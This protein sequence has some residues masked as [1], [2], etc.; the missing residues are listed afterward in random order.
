MAFRFLLRTMVLSSIFGK[1][2]ENIMVLS[3]ISAENHPK[4][5]AR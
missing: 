3:R 1:N 4:T 5:L 2:H